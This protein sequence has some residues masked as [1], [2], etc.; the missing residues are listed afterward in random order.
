MK[1]A[2]A[3]GLSVGS[4]LSL[5]AL[6]LAVGT[7]TQSVSVMSEAVHSGLD[8]L[9][10]AIALFSIQQARKPA[11]AGH[12]FGHGKIENISGVI[13]SLLVLAAALWIIYESWQRLRS[14]VTVRWV[15]LGLGVMAVS[16]GVN[17]YLSGV[18][19]RVARSEDSVALAADA[20][21][22]RTDAWTSLGVFAGLILIRLTGVAVIDP[23]LAL[24]VAA[25]IIRSALRLTGESLRPLVDASLPE[26]ELSAITRII[27][28]HSDQF[29]EFHALRS[30]RAGPERHIDLHL[31]VPK[32][33]HVSEVHALCDRIEAEI[34]RDFPLSHTLIHVEPCNEAC[35]KCPRHQ[36]LPSP[37]PPS[38]EDTQA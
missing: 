24:V 27:E 28:K 37:C 22:L 20:L 5:V 4:N 33:L 36:G 1:A 14:G 26:E 34:R 3:A 9:A 25:I 23:L 29:V 13:E 7:M 6:K 35:R 10:S 16:A 38:P 17:Y 15:G 21:H 31:V 2:R 18:L 19:G 8:L 32:D 11:D 30:R 12:R